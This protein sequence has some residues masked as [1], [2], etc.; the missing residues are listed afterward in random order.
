MITQKRKP[1]LFQSGKYGITERKKAELD[2]LSNEVL[3]AQYVADE[4]QAVVSSLT[5]KSARFAAFLASAEQ[6]RQ[7][8]LNNQN[9]LDALIQSALNLRNNSQTAFTTVVLADSQT[10]EVAIEIK[11]VT[12]RLIYSAEVIDKLSNLIARNKAANPLISNDLVNL[13]AQAG[14]DANNAVALTLVALNSTFASQAS[15]LEAEA[16]SALEYTQSMK[17][18]EILTGTNNQGKEWHKETCLKTLIDNAYK[19]SE[20]AYQSALQ[21]NIDTLKQLNI[22][23]SDLTK[24]QIQLKS[25]QSGLAAAN[26]AAFAS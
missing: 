14:K 7:Q 13:I 21:A 23:T 20:V 1:N 12:D 22:A 2:Q 8:A 9:M 5:D 10:K 4:L 11:K 18:Y 6:D 17:L 15:S 25:L 24:A 3:D 19:N 16:V 26:A